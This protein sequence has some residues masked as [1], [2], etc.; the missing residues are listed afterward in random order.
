MVEL[1]CPDY[2]GSTV[3]ILYHIGIMTKCTHHVIPLSHDM[4]VPN[5]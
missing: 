1:K 3:Y 5:V 2:R 4:D